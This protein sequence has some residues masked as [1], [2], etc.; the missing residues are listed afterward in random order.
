MNQYRI[1]YGTAG[2]LV[3]SIDEE[4]GE[5][6]P[7]FLR[8][9]GFKSTKYINLPTIGLTHVNIESMR[10]GSAR[11]GIG[12][13][14][15]NYDEL[16]T[17]PFTIKEFKTI[18]NILKKHEYNKKQV[19]SSN[20]KY[21]NSGYACFLVKDD[22][23]KNPDNKFWTYLK[24]EKFKQLTKNNTPPEWVLINVGNSTYINLTDNDEIISYVNDN[25]ANALNTSEFMIIWE[26]IRKHR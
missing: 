2:F 22:N 25:Y 17:H 24:D 1:F 26:E 15:N 8:D 18:W 20:R 19:E 16:P 5:E 4:S 11:L 9:E 6:L 12:I 7:T 23:L 3:E 14:L 21:L 13:A 10:Y